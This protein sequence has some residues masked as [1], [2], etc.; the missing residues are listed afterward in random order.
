MKQLSKAQIVGE[1]MQK[2]VLNE[3]LVMELLDDCKNIIRMHDAIEDESYIY[4]VMEYCKCVALY[5]SCG[6]SSA[7]SAPIIGRKVNDAIA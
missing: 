2:A 1:K 7:L 3:M 4:F 5:Q 6:S